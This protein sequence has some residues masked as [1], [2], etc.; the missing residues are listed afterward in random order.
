MNRFLIPLVLL[1]PA[2]LCCA[3]LLGEVDEGKIVITA[4]RPVQVPG[5]DI[6]SAAGLLIPIP[7][8]GETAPADPFS[9]LLA[10]TTRQV[11]FG[12][13]NGNVTLDGR[14]VTPVGYEPTGDFATDVTIAAG[15]HR[16]GSCLPNQIRITNGFPAICAPP[17]FELGRIEPNEGGSQLFSSVV[18]ISSDYPDLALSME[19]SGHSVFT[20]PNFQPTLAGNTADYDVLVD[21]SVPAGRYE[22]LVTLEIV[23][24]DGVVLVDT[25]GSTQ[26]RLA[27]EIVPEPSSGGMPLLPLCLLL[28]HSARRTARRSR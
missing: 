10:N 6:Q 4:D 9:F 13:L 17:V 3:Q 20:I 15:T 23:L 11:T 14:W 7:L 26:F 24:P 1:L 16:P 22:A 27:A 18:S 25:G 8:D 2:E 12:I 5:V 19:G 21:T 28:F